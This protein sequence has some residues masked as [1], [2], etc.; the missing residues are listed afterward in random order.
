MDNIAI[1]QILSTVNGGDD[2]MASLMRDLQHRVPTVRRSQPEINK[3]H[4]NRP[5]DPVNSVSSAENISNSDS[6]ADAIE[7]SRPAQ[8]SRQVPNQTSNH[9]QRQKAS[10][11]VQAPQAPVVSSHAH[12]TEKVQSKNMYKDSRPNTAPKKSVKINTGS[13]TGSQDDDGTNGA[14]GDVDGENGTI[15]TQTDKGSKDDNKVALPSHLTN[16]FGYNIPTSTLY[17]IIVLVIIAVGLYFLT[18]ER[19]KPNKDGDK[20][21]DKNKKS[22]ENE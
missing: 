6:S 9:I 14:D 19:K 4:V 21:K 10:V 2:D 16:I 1:D 22:Q 20:D 15:V 3:S 11:H 12:P 18:A 13:D 5:N 17:F 7:V 8:V